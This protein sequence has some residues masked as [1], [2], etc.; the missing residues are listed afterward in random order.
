MTEK[1]PET[2]PS[3]VLNVDKP[4]GPTS[5]E[6]VRT[7]RRLSGQRKV[8]H[9]GTLDPLATGVLLLCLGRATRVSKY[10]MASPKTYQA[11]IRLGISTTTHD[12]EGTIIGQAPVNVTRP[13]VEAALAQ[14]VGPIQ[15]VPPMH[16]AIK[17]AGKRLYQ[18]A[19]QGK[20]V[21]V[22]PRR[23]DVYSLHLTDCVPPVVRLQVRCGP[24]TYIRALARDLGDAL[25]CGAH[26]ASLRRTESGG[27]SIE[28]SVT[29][30][31]L[32]QAF[33]T[34]TWTGLLHPLDVAFHHLPAI[35]LEPRLARRVAMGQQVENDID[36]SSGME[37]RVYAQNG[38][39]VAVVRRDETSGRWQ[40]RQVF[41]APEDIPMC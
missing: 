27:F 21:E 12:A 19:R 14:F 32:E 33:T 3:G 6:V 4:L 16:S 10:L 13:E 5:Y 28:Q 30:P 25:G 24:G 26:L 17:H 36:I 29:L 11:E 9:T 39:F 34:G 22:P 35:Q 41:V 20:T 37:A 8:G 2:A 31:D 38:Q 18:L 1:A 23:V 40:P 15:Q 7:V